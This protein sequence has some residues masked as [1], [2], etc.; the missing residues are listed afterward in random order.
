[1]ASL[2]LEQVAEE[3]KTLPLEE[4]RQLRKLLEA[5][6][7]KH[8]QLGSQPSLDRFAREMAWIQKHRAEFAGQWVA[9]DGE[10]LLAA[11]PIA[12]EVF[13]AAR[14]SGIHQPLVTK[15]EPLDALPFGGW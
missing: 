7:A 8:L 14:T 1:M 2:T 6:E 10:R 12:Q 9:L 5:E 13:A 11:G 15:I 3:A 4:Q